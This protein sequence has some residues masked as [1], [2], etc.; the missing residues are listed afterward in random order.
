MP[1][2]KAEAVAAFRAAQT[3]RIRL[4]ELFIDCRPLPPMTDPVPVRGES[5]DAWVRAQTVEREA[6]AN[7]ESFG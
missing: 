3:E 2:T 4:D 7:L 1:T 5:I 6:L